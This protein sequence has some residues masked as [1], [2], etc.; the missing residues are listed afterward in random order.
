[1]REIERSIMLDLEDVILNDSTN[2]TPERPTSSLLENVNDSRIENS[3]H[4]SHI[5]NQSA[6][7]ASIR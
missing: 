2:L 1:M 6:L 7:D 3:K 5:V 4:E